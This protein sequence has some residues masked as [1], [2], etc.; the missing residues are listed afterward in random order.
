MSVEL[1][2]GDLL[3]FI[4]RSGKAR[5]GVGPVMFIRYGIPSDTYTGNNWVGL[6]LAHLDYMLDPGY[7]MP[8]PKGSPDYHWEK[9]E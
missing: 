2:Y 7:P 5:E 3:V 9:V 8:E 1:K 6:D 4:E